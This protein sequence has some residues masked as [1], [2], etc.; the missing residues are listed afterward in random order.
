MLQSQAV[1]LFNKRLLARAV[2]TAKEKEHKY[3]VTG[4][5]MG[6][7]TFFVKEHFAKASPKDLSEGKNTMKEAAAKW[8]SLDEASRKRYEELSRQYRDKK[9]REFEELS[10][11]E[12]KEMIAASLHEK[13][14]RAKRKSRKE[15]KENWEKTGHP[16]RPPSAY[17]I[18]VQ[19][20]YNQLKDQGEVITPV[21]KTMHRSYNKRAAKLFSEYKSKL[22]SWKAANGRKPEENPKSPPVKE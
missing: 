16:E 18:F 9:I 19:E 1:C 7:M 21:S 2:S 20:R 5:T 8:K 12:K 15:R 17:N 6:P 11:E 22:E 4:M 13:E 10:E 3:P 14:E